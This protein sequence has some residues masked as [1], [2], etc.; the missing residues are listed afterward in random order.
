[1]GNAQITPRDGALPVLPSEA[2]SSQAQDGHEHERAFSMTR[3]K[4][5]AHSVD[6]KKASNGLES[7]TTTKGERSRYLPKAMLNRS[8]NGVV[9]PSGPYGSGAGGPYSAKGNEI[10]SPQW[11][12]YISITPP[13]EIHHSRITPPTELYHSRI[14]PATT[15]Q[16]KQSS[17]SNISQASSDTAASSDSSTATSQ[18]P[19]RIFQDMQERQQGASMG[20]ANVPL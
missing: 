18:Q 13:T 6:A 10:E 15:I 16:K 17:S 11:G 4:L 20:W 2:S 12:W 14:R 8:N 1:M 9:M 3:T 5:A 19:N 7:T